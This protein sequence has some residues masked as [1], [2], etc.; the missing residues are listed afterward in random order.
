LKH[1]ETDEEL[2][3]NPTHAHLAEP[4]HIIVDYE[5]PASG[6]DAALNR[7]MS[8]SSFTLSYYSHDDFVPAKSA[9]KILL[10]PPA[11][12]E[13]DVVKK[14]QVVLVLTFLM[15]NHVLKAVG[16]FASWR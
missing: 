11:S 12:E 10:H 16:S 5:G 9:L 2:S 8:R 14:Q 6:K 7:G 3:K 1:G 13:D 15:H 4:L